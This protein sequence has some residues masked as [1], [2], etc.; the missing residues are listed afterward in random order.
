[1]GSG[2][3]IIPGLEPTSPYL[4]RSLTIRNLLRHYAT[5]AL[6]AVSRRDFGMLVRKNHK[7]QT[8]LI[9]EILTAEV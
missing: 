4:K 5:Q 9:A 8:V 6:N 2:P 7:R 1:M 3:G